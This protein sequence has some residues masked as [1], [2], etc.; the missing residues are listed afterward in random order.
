MARSFDVSISNA[1]SN[2][3]A[4]VVEQSAL[5]VVPWRVIELFNGVDTRVGRSAEFVV[6]SVRANW[7]PV[8]I[9]GREG[10]KE[11]VFS[12]YGAVVRVKDA[13]R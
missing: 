8:E 7:P 9:G 13:F 11:R 5:V 4:S 1:P 2:V 3:R 6:E 10:T 12:A